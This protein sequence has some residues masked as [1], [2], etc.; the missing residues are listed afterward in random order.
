MQSKDGWPVKAIAELGNAVGEVMT[1]KL[2]KQDRK[3]VAK[4]RDHERRMHVDRHVAIPPRAPLKAMPFRA[5]SIPGKTLERM[6][7]VLE[8]EP[9]A[10]VHQVAQRFGYPVSLVVRELADH[11]ANYGRFVFMRARM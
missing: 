6:V 10:D 1:K 5:K 2:K 4:I 7:E 11:Q 8:T 3:I 9:E